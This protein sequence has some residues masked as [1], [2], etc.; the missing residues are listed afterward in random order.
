ME[1]NNTPE[2][3]LTDILKEGRQI[4]IERAEA[5]KPVTEEIFVHEV[6]YEDIV[7][8]PYIKLLKND[9]REMFEWLL[10]KPKGWTKSLTRESWQSLRETEEAI[11][12]DFALA[13]IKAIHDRGG[14]L[15]FIDEQIIEQAKMMMSLVPSATN[16]QTTPGYK[17]SVVSNAS[18]RPHP[19]L[20]PS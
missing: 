10:D 7:D 6:T 1:K 19:G 9:I 3:N 20:K 4:T 12:F 15:K 2:Q 11:N 5:G 8:G 14:Q 17:K 16:L 18:K 13:E